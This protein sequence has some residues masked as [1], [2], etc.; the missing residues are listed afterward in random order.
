MRRASRN[1]T[2]FAWGYWGRGRA[3]R[4]R[5]GRGR[6][7]VVFFCSCES[8]DCAS[9]CH[10]M[11][12]ATTLLRA[13]QKAGVALTV[14]EWPGG[15]PTLRE[16]ARFRVVP[17]GLKSVLS[18]N[19]WAP[20]AARPRSGRE[21]GFPVGSLVRLEEGGRSLVGAACSPRL[22]GKAWK[23][24]LLVSAADRKGRALL[25]RA[26]ATR[27]DLGLGARTT[28]SRRAR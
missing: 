14:D 9:T 19:L 16:T 24:P 5:A 18:G 25:R 21:I 7:R 11:L 28:L 27:H 23:L 3:T 10:R 8:P 6:R 22:V 12:V 20:L 13:A 2:A 1:L 17:G 15:S 4:E 26:L